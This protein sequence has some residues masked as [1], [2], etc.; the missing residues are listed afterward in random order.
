GPQRRKTAR[1]CSNCKTAHLPC[2]DFRPCRRCVQRD[3]AASCITASR[4]KAKYL[5]GIDERALPMALPT[6][7]T[8][9]ATVATSVDSP[10]STRQCMFP[11]FGSEGMNQEYGVISNL[12]LGFNGGESFTA[13]SGSSSSMNSAAA[14]VTMAASH[15]PTS[16][17]LTTATNG[18][19]VPPATATHSCDGSSTSQTLSYGSTAKAKR[20]LRTSPRVA[21]GQDP[22]E[23]NDNDV[24]TSVTEPYDY[25]DGFHYLLNYVTA[26][27]DRAS[28]LRICKA[29][30]HF[31]PSFMA[32]TMNLTNQD[33]IFMEQCFQ[34]TLR[35]YEKLIELTGTPTVVCRRTGEIALVGTEFAM[36]TRTPRRRLLE[37][38]RYIYEL[39]DTASAVDYWE[40]FSLMAFDN[41]AHT[42]TG[43][44]RQ[45]SASQS[46]IPCAFCYTVRRDIFNMPLVIVGNWLPLL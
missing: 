41:T 39:M 45:S 38:R 12:L 10:T 25:R 27:M 26:R 7:T 40:K 14:T 5:A 15:S 23:E 42:S 2:N 6:T 36:L 21:T 13:T 9:T 46:T 17:L 19:V 22:A 33:L 1:A 44:C 34:R 16:H 11:A 32:T 43:T 29:L 37:Q 28:M 4:R 31:R 30:A 18:S 20:G 8:A 3:I 24:Y 35:E